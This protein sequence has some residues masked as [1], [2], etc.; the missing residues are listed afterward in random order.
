ME[1]YF[2]TCIICLYVYFHT[3]V[4]LPWYFEKI[5]K[6]ELHMKSYFCM[7]S[8]RNRN[9]SGPSFLS[10]GLNTKIYKVNLRV[11][12]KCGKTR[13]IKTPNT[14]TFYAVHDAVSSRLSFRHRIF[15][16]IILM[17]QKIFFFTLV[18]NQWFSR[19]AGIKENYF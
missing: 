9:F 11:K 4:S 10:F 13:S 16:Y 17:W 8:V 5:L 14:D 7:K 1:W 18:W 3:I 12:P 2:Y 19:R 6:W 15:L